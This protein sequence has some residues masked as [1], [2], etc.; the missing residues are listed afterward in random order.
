MGFVRSQTQDGSHWVP[1]APP[2]SQHHSV[3]VAPPSTPHTLPPTLNFSLLKDR[4][5]LPSLS[6]CPK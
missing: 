1:E 6:L 2:S 5:L 3:P 4:L